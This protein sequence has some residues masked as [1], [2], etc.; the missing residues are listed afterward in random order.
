MANIDELPDILC[1]VCY[2]PFDNEKHKSHVFQCG[3]HVCINCLAELR[4]TSS[5][6]VCMYCRNYS[7]SYNDNNPRTSASLLNLSSL[8]KDHMLFQINRNHYLAQRLEFRKICPAHQKPAKMYDVPKAKP[9]C[10]DCLKQY[11]NKVSV[12][13]VKLQQEIKEAK[14]KDL[15]EMKVFLEGLYLNENTE[16]KGVKYKAR[17]AE[18]KGQIEGTMKTRMDRL[19]SE[20]DNLKQNLDKTYNAVLG[21]IK[22][23]HE[24]LKTQISK[25]HEYIDLYELAAKTQLKRIEE[26]KNAPE[27]ERNDKIL[28]YDFSITD[29]ITVENE[30]I[31]VLNRENIEKKSNQSLDRTRQLVESVTKIVQDTKVTRQELLKL[32]RVND[33]ETVKKNLELLRSVIDKNQVKKEKE[34]VEVDPDVGGL[35]EE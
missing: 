18:L 23:Y 28:A 19:Q 4:N 32:A 26:I 33:P 20:F 31:N 7:D 14:I 8:F 12:L 29:F 27:S 15:D 16:T 10:I 5:N 30:L 22:L 11:K 25:G 34:V 2:E 24:N 17:M 21:N 13:N 1:S 35:F 9:M 6:V 3:H